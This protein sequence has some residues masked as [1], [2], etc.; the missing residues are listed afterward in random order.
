[1]TFLEVII[2]GKHVLYSY[3]FYGNVEIVSA[4]AEAIKCSRN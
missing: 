4:D 1:M 2:G 3:D